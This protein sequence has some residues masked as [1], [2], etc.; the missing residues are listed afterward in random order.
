M[1]TVG[2]TASDDQ[3]KQS[4]SDPS[5]IVY[6][7]QFKPQQIKLDL[8]SKE[9]NMLQRLEKLE[10]LFGVPDKMVIIVY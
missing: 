7:L 2:K 9:A 6:Q 4:P 1:E 5:K 10:S 8:A 3:G